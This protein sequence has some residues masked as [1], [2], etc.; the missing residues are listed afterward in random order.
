[1][2]IAVLGHGTVGS[3]VCEILLSRAREISSAA[4]KPVEL[5]PVLDIREP[6]NVPYSEKFIKDFSAVLS[7]PEIGIVAECIGGLE[8]AYSYIKSPLECGKR[9]RYLKQ[10]TGC[11]KGCGTSE[12]RP[13]S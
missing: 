3:G 6:E 12:H 11:G 10:G 2:K 5:G 1:M 13:C 4:G 7:D 9:R 8:P